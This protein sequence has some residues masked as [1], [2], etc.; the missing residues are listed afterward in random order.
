M[1]SHIVFV[2]HP[3]RACA[4]VVLGLTAVVA[5][6][7]TLEAQPRTQVS[8][9][10][11][12]RPADSPTILGGIADDQWRLAQLMGRADASGWM[13]RT[14]STVVA[15][16]R[17]PS[18]TGLRWSPIGPA[19]DVAW[20]S[21]L[22]FSIN[23][24]SL[25]AGRGTNV[26]VTGGVGAQLWRVRARFVPEL[27]HAQNRGFFIEPS[28][29]EGRKSFASPWHSGEWSADLPLRLGNEPVTTVGLGQSVVALDLD[30]VEIG[31]SN[32]GQWWGPAIRNGIVLSNNAGGIPH[33]FLRTPRP[34]GTTLGDV[35]LRWIAGV[36]TESIQF[37]DDPT[38]DQRAL[39][40]FVATMRP[41]AA[42]DLTLGIAR[43]VFAESDGSGDALAHGADVFTRWTRLGDSTASGDGADQMLSLFGRW[44]LPASGAEFYGEWVRLEPP[45]S[46]RELIVA[47]QRSQ[48][49][50]AGLQW[51]RSL[52]AGLFRVQAE[53]T[54]LE[55][56]PS[57]PGAIRSFYTSNAVRQGYTQRGQPLGAA[58][59]P[60]GSSQWLAVDRLASRW[61]VGL[62]L[63]RIR[64][65]NDVYYTQPTGVAYFSHD[66]STLVGVRGGA[67][68]F[69]Y[70]LLLEATR[71]LRRNYLFQNIRGGFGADPT[72]DVPNTTVR[73]RLEPR[74][75]ILPFR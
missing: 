41:A 18:A 4:T 44:V 65:E 46:L 57:A 2:T 75:R 25:W 22:P 17:R 58:I 59:G 33:L 64:W 72:F 63:G 68:V 69:G 6:V 7:A 52:R 55:Q 31:A 50:T 28:L 51:A 5:G 66:V 49:W 73:V 1:N 13:M 53:A 37:D 70:D 8:D 16:P 43:V 34:L 3:T 61:S 54:T 21:A 20:N 39:S 26:L 30:R 67:T 10:A 35:E 40:G 24:G 27:T 14:P 38:N 56:T 12:M 48:G 15:S 45:S 36:L 29:T 60:G 42:R 74:T 9:A 23:D 71:G 11:V 32:E 47:P 19:L 62:Q